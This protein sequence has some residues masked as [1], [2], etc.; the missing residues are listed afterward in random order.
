MTD[1]LSLLIALF[2]LIISIFALCVVIFKNKFDEKRNQFNLKLLM[3]DRCHIMTQHAIKTRELIFKIENIKTQEG[4]LKLSD[5]AF[6]NI[7]DAYA[8]VNSMENYPSIESNELNLLQIM[9]I[10]KGNLENLKMVSNEVFS[11]QKTSV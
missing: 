4:L 6:E 3:I 9:K 10:E 2:S 1:S 5:R 7:S 8:A 11:Q